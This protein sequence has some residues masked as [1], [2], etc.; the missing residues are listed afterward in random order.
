MS[1]AT[2]GLMV[3]CFWI[4]KEKGGSL[5]LVEREEGGDKREE[6][7]FGDG[8]RKGR[9]LFFER[10]SVTYL[11]LLFLQISGQTPSLPESL[12]AFSIHTMNLPV[13]C[14]LL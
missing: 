5:F 2:Q 9:E 1:V 3:D 6:L 7:M 4:V 12:L 14:V 10:E 11:T 13:N 8:K